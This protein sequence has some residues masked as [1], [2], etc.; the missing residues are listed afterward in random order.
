[1]AN[2]LLFTSWQRRSFSSRQPK[3]ARACKAT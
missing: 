2:N 3:G 1:M